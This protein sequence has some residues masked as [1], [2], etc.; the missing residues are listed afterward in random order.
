MKKLNEIKLHEI[1]IKICLF[2]QNVLFIQN[3]FHFHIHKKLENFLNFLKFFKIL[4]IK[5]Y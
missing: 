1:H 5:Y 2:I 4:F 3:G